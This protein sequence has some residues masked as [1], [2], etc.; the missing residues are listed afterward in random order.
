MSNHNELSPRYV[1]EP[2]LY[3]VAVALVPESAKSLHVSICARRT[4]ISNTSVVDAKFLSSG[5]VATLFLSIF[6]DHISTRTSDILSLFCCRSMQ[7]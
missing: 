6:V 3:L 1:M 5:A 2:G 7:P 4:Y